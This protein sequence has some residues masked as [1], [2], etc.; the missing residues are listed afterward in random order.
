[1]NR[2]LRPIARL[3]PVVED[4]GDKAR[5]GSNVANMR[6]IGGLLAAA[7]M[8]LA[9]CGGGDD[10]APPPPPP[11][12]AVLPPNTLGLF[13]TASGVDVSHG[14]F[15]DWTTSDAAGN[16]ITLSKSRQ[17]ALIVPSTSQWI[18]LRVTSN[19]DWFVQEK[20]A[21]LLTVS[22]NNLDTFFAAFNLQDNTF[23]PPRLAGTR[24]ADF[25]FVGERLF[26]RQGTF[27]FTSGPDNREFRVLSDLDGGTTTTLLAGNDPDN[28]GLNVSDGAI[29]YSVRHDRMAARLTVHTRNQTT[30][31][32][33]TQLRDLP[34]PDQAQYR[35][36]WSMKINRG[37]LYVLRVH[38]ADRRLEILTTDLR[39]ANTALGLTLLTSFGQTEGTFDNSGISSSVW[40]VD[41]GTIAFAVESGGML[42]PRNK[43]V[44]Y[45]SGT[46]VTTRYDQNRIGF[47]TEISTLDVVLRN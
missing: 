28:I 29:L 9:A 35:F 37:I 15:R 21:H 5:G 27:M 11:T 24:V 42:G 47:N 6:C 41:D 40:G 14:S 18:A 26:H 1:M 3:P 20:R 7:A 45:D 36:L 13:V 2:E 33:E 34:L 23:G 12:P 30:G 19:G 46:G 43:I 4:E 31:Q 10:E 25:A 16:I 39:I 17:V 32:L 8:L 22:D 38:D 44:V